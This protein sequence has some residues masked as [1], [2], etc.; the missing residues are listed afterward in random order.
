MSR[1]RFL[2]LLAVA[3]VAI[4]GAIFLSTQRNRAGDT[5]S[6][7]LLPFLAKQINAI[8]ELSIRKGSPTPVVT[9][10]K[11]GDQWNVVERGNYPADVAKLRRLLLSLND[12]RILEE[13]TSNPASYSV[14]GVEDPTKAGAAGIQIEM[15]APDGTHGVIV[16]KPSGEGSFVRREGDAKSYIVRPALSVEAEPRFWIDTRLLDLKAADIER[17]DVKPATGPA[18]SIHRIP[19]TA[20]DTT[21]A[22]AILAVAPPRDF[23][24]D[25]VPAGRKATD[26]QTLAP[27]PT[28]YSSLSIDDVADAGTVD[29]TKPSSVTLSFKGDDV[30]TITGTI[31]GDKHWIQVTT[32]K[33]MALN[34]KAAARAFEISNFRYD[35]VFR[36]LE[37]LLVPK[38]PPPESKKPASTLP[39]ASK[40]P[41]SSKLP[42]T[43]AS[44]ATP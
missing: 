15:A 19:A 25:G 17:I 1:Q 12:A 21:A 31:I 4:C 32:T 26:S 24:L 22:G 23:V 10:R 2:V 18:Y 36:P 33:D 42:G 34:T 40:F 43:N 9:V 7:P 35:A 3:F 5:E 38:P 44:P 13:K 30:V 6:G 8:S 16:G 41:G 39:A 29:F 11:R 14:I 20:A 28:T 37:Q 27:S